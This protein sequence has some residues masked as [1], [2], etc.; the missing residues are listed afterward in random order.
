MSQ[1]EEPCICTRWAGECWVEQMSRLYGRACKRQCGCIATKLSR[2]NACENWK[3][4]R[5]CGSQ[6]SIWSD[7]PENL[8][9]FSPYLFGKQ[10]NN[11]LLSCQNSCWSSFFMLV[12]FCNIVL[13]PLFFF[14]SFTSTV[15]HSTS[16]TLSPHCFCCFFAYFTWCWCD[17]FLL[18]FY[19]LKNVFNYKIGWC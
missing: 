2:L 7:I 4:V 10:Y 1:I 18:L 11:V 16:G 6:A 15:A 9:S 5:W 17:A 8:K 19:Y 12:T 3:V 13:M 14:L